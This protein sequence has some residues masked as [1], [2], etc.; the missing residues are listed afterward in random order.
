MSST[1]GATALYGILGATLGAWLFGL[2]PPAGPQFNFA[3]LGDTAFQLDIPGALRLGIVEII[4]VFFF[5]DLFDNLGTLMAVTK[6]A[7]LA[8]ADGNIPRLGR[9]LT[10]D[11]IATM[12]DPW[13]APRL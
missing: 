4:F 3:R 11:A 7:G 6:K 10:V 13:R 9:I 12:V 5:V 8:N 2:M 1:S